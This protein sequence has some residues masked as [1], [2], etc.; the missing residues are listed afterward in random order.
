M[1]KIQKTTKNSKYDLSVIIPV[2]NEA[3][4]IEETLRLLD[5][6][7]TVKNQILVIYDLDNDTTLPVLK[8]LK[9]IYPQLVILKNSIHRGPSGAIRTG[10]KYSSG[11]K[12]LVTMA[13]LCD[14]LTQ[15]KEMLNLIPKTADVVCPSRYSKGGKQELNAPLK[16]GFPKLA[17]R[18]LQLFTGINTSDPTNSYKM[19]SS[20]LIHNISLKS[21][22]SFSVT[23]E[24]VAKAHCLEYKIYEIPTIWKDRQHGKTNFK[25]FQSIFSYTPW[26]CLA[27]LNN[28]LFH[29]PK[30]WLL[31]L[32]R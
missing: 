14:D 4:N 19:Y 9:R 26:F 1:K 7:I 15:I 20:E 32:I 27:L 29:T 2:Y 11:S 10:F 13:D 30:S 3:A 6:N 24:I 22:S 5:K 8:N 28:R 18:L 23:L 17:G 21:V 25:L 12:I 16:V 31:L